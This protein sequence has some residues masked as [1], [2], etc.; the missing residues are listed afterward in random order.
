MSVGV[1]SLK[2]KERVNN[3]HFI[4]S[5]VQARN[6]VIVPGESSCPRA[7]NTPA[8]LALRS[9][10]FREEGERLWGCEGTCRVTLLPVEC[11][12]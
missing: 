12:T 11:L 10:R 3:R 7:P 5:A 9:W 4:V 1:C 8:L 2:V 6:G